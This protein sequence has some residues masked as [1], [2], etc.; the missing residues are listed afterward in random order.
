M[1][2]NGER[3]VYA[4]IWDESITLFDMQ[5]KALWFKI[6]SRVRLWL[7]FFILPLYIFSSGIQFLFML[8]PFCVLTWIIDYK[9]QNEN[10]EI[11]ELGS[12]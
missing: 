8:V 7:S 10:Q 4:E 1:K 3:R 6:P 5:D 2:N 9:P 12:H 11:K